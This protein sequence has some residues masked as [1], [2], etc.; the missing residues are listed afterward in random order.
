MT[1]HLTKKF[2][3]MPTSFDLL[4][5]PKI[6]HVLKKM[7]PTDKERSGGNSIEQWI[8]FSFPLRTS[9]AAELEASKKS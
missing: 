3:T 7:S 1:G 4:E 8:T 6:G 2:R 5:L 9:L